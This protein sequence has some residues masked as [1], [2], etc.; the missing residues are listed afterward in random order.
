MLGL[1]CERCV[2]KQAITDRN[3]R[4]RII[5]ALCEPG[6]YL[7]DSCDYLQ[8]EPP[9]DAAYLLA[10]ML[11]DVAEWRFRMTSSNN[12][13]SAY[14]IDELPLPAVDD[15]GAESRAQDVAQLMPEGL[16]LANSADPVSDAARFV[17][18][19]LMNGTSRAALHD[20]IVGIVN[21][22]STLRARAF[23]ELDTFN[24]LLRALP[25]GRRLTTTFAMGGWVALS[26]PAFF[27]E[28][29]EREVRLGAANVA[30]LRGDRRTVLAALRPVVEQ[31]DRLDEALN[32]IALAL[33][34]LTADEREVVIQNLPP[35]PSFLPALA[36]A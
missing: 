21:H 27:T 11:C 33:F 34:D 30:Q 18:Q 24:L 1:R 16:A 25:H 20:V 9:Y 32:S 15:W 19:A 3:D 17:T 6:R 23:A 22:V 10:I 29:A 36:P 12:N 35:K 28:I 13:V 2:V 7:L 4:R 26:E 8:P 14:E 5:A 31:S